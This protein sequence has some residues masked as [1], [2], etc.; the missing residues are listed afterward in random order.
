VPKREGMSTDQR[1]RPTTCPSCGA[2]VR[3]DVSWCSLCYASLLPDRV[4]EPVPVPV[5]PPAAVASVDQVEAITDGLLAEL[6]ASRDPQPAWVG[7]LPTSAAGRGGLIVGAVAV[8]T[9][10]LF[11]AMS[12]LGLFL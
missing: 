9:L 7:H 10:L 4:V 11:A 5:V 3:T 12:L 2:A 6:A 8:G 1:H